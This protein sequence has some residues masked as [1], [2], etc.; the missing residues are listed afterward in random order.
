MTKKTLCITALCAVCFL[1]MFLQQRCTTIQAEQFAQTSSCYCGGQVMPFNNQLPNFS[2]LN[3]T[4]A[5]CFGWQEFIALNQPVDTN[6]GFGDPNDLGLVQWETY[7][8]TYAI[9]RKG[10]KPPYP[11]R[12]Q[13]D[14]PSGANAKKFRSGKYLVLEDNQKVPKGFSSNQV[15]LNNNPAWLGAQNGTNVWYEVLVNEVEYDYIVNNHLYNADSQYFRSFAGN[16][17]FLPENAM[18]VKAAWMELSPEDTTQPRYNNIKQRF[19]LSLAYV[20]DSPG[21][22]HRE[23][24]VALIGLHII[25]KVPGQ[26]SLVWATFEQADNNLA[27]DNTI[28]HPLGYNLYNSNCAAQNLNVKTV[29]GHDTSVTIACAPNVQPPYYLVRGNEP[30][31]IQTS[32]TTM[33]GLTEI[34]TNN[35]IIACIQQ[36]NPSSVWQYYRLINTIWSSNDTPDSSNKNNLDSMT[37]SSINPPIVS[38]VA[39]TTLETY[40]QSTNCL[41]SCHKFATTARPS[42]DTDKQ[43][44]TPGYLAD[45]S[46]VFG[47]AK[48]AKSSS[49]PKAGHHSSTG[50]K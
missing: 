32:R 35:R 1:T 29:A 15:V 3:Q 27:L 39:N 9:F 34:S 45:F 33:V 42:F 50:I 26:S 43:R 22:K 17:I 5:D 18:E 16:K 12:S 25:R 11:W 47:L 2:I 37:V 44:Q 21:G 31:P 19:K 28:P 48:T 13:G 8:P 49:L 6:K 7:M 36:V 10:A 23:T 4:M 24:V 38:F 14:L 30:A 41:N 40:N 46:F 20:Q